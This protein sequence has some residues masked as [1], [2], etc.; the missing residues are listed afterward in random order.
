MSAN[1]KQRIEQQRHDNAKVIHE[2]LYELGQH[3]IASNLESINTDENGLYEDEASIYF[4]LSAILNVREIPEG[5][6]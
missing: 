6:R 4:Y 2:A 3:R 1:E 5:A